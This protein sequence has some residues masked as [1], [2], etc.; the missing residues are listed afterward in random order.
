LKERPVKIRGG[1]SL[2]VAAQVLTLAFSLTAVAIAAPQSAPM[3]APMGSAFTYQGSLT[4]NGVAANG[5]YDFQ[6]RLYETATAI[7][8]IG[9]TVLREDVPV[10][11]GVFAIDLDFG[12]AVFT[13]EARFLDVGVRPGTSS[14]LFTQMTPRQLLNPVPY[15]IFATNAGTA[16]SAGILGTTTNLALDLNVNNARAF[17]LE[18]SATSPNVV[19]GTPQTPPPLPRRACSARPSEVA[20]RLAMRTSSPIPTESSAAV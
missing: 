13:G 11:N 19:G 3:M 5:I 10:V 6:F 14:G 7:N 16:G 1:I 15:A 9:I 8:Q 12:T 4:D 18:P 20:A 2:L 17:R